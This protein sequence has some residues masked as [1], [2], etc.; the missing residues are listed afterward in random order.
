MSAPRFSHLFA[1]E[2]R[3]VGRSPLL[4]AILMILAASFGWGAASTARLHSAQ[5]AAAEGARTADAAFLESTAERSRAYRAAVT[6]TATP[7]AYWQDPTSVSGYSEYFVRRSA[8]KPHLPLSPLAAGVS[9]MVPSRLEI[10]LNTPFGFVDTYDFENPRG[11]ALGRF[12]LAFTVVFLLP[13]GLLLLI[14]LL[15]TFER[16]RGMLPLIAAQSVGPRVWIGARIAA[17]LAWAIPVVALAMIVA[18]GLAGVPISAVLAP[19]AV[20]ILVTILYML[21]WSGLALLLLARQPGAGAALG[22][23][24]ALWAALTIGLPLAVSVIVAVVDPAPS[25]LEY[26]D[27]QRR[28]GDE[29]QEARHAILTDAL[30]KRPYLRAHV[31][32]VPTL[33]HATRLSF[34]VPEVERRLMSSKSVSEAH[35]ARQ[36]RIARVVGFGMPTLGVETVFATLA[37]T[38]PARQREF[39]IQARHYQKQLRERVYPLV[40]REIARPPAPTDRPVRGHMSLLKP[41]A[42][43]EFEFVD[44]PAGRRI[45]SALAFAAWLSVVTSVLIALGMSRIR[46]WRVVQP[47]KE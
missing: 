30:L 23:F 8:F 33:D 18:L 29:V 12:D 26:V 45:S 11:L 21:F 34:L 15:V 47:T 46:D 9:E 31:D 24:A 7:V 40:Q 43:P 14:A 35:R 42:L 3:R 27:A 4:W 20:T 16:D 32:R 1:W 5:E 13:I 17:I 25:A 36:E 41:L 6:A 38:D 37:G 39:E 44:R 28:V 2:W 22:S 10:K 19:L